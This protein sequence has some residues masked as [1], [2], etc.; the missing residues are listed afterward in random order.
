MAKPIFL[1]DMFA[2]EYAAF[3]KLKNN[4]GT[5]AE[6]AEYLNKRYRPKFA[7]KFTGDNLKAQRLALN[8]EVPRER[9]VEHFG[10]TVSTEKNKI[11]NAVAELVRKANDGEKYVSQEEILRRLKKTFKGSIPK[12][13]EPRY[14]TSL[15][16]LE[17][18]YDKIDKTLKNLLSESKPLNKYWMRALENRTGFGYSQYLMNHLNASPTY[19]FHIENINALKNIHQMPEYE[20]LK[21]KPMLDQIKIAGEVKSGQPIFTG[22]GGIKIR[23]RAPST[24]VMEFAKRSWHNTRGKG[25]V[26]FF[27]KNGRITWDYGVK[28]PYHKVSFSHGGGKRHNVG[29]LT[30]PDYIKKYF[31]EVYDTRRAL[32]K[33]S[34]RQVDNPFKKGKISVKELIQ[35]IQKR[36]FGWKATYGSLDILHGPKGVALEPFKNLTISSKDINTLE[37]GLDS[38]LRWKTITKEQAAKARKFL[39]QDIKGLTGLALEDAIID[40]QFNVVKN[41]KEIKAGGGYSGWSERLRSIFNTSTSLKEKHRFAVFMG[42]AGDAE[43]GRIGY[44]LGTGVIR[45][46][47]NKLTQQPVESSQKIVAGIEEGATGILGKMRNVSKGF[48][49][50]LGKF[51][52]KVGKYGAIVAAGAA[53]EPVVKLFRNDDPSTYLTDPDQQAGMLEALI[54]GETPKVDEEMLKWQMPALGAATAAGAIPGAGAAYRAR[55]GVGPT[56]PLPGGVGKVRAALGLKGVLGKALGASFSPLAV[57]ATL[58]MHVAA[59]RS[60]GT[61]WGDIATDPMNWMAPAFAS[62]GAEFATKGMKPT[63]IMSQ[64]IRL[65]MKPSTLRMISSKL[66]WPGLLLTGGMWGYDK[67]K[68]RSIN[69]ED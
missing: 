69:D 19:Q 12:R 30:K 21:Q 67:W 37:A 58:P 45:C 25:A 40:R 55:R 36:A 15:G 16:T 11:K 9:Y 53:I 66:G 48:L 63:G 31:R 27:D 42:C 14:I 52:P 26:Q 3:Q 17:T 5:D 59:Q 34:A 18:P 1:M 7:K 49:G 29:E 39:R 47:N 54:E 35:E 44:A 46:V 65:G 2:K 8:I 13:I 57:A 61:E 51:G 60:G 50:A 6:F 28:L 33:L 43:G 62:S 38:S 64:A 68:N 22:L 41:L 32:N 56:G 10:S 23:S 20:F 24:D 4:Q